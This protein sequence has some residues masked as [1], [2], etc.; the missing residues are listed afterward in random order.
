M[1]LVFV[2][3]ARLFDKNMKLSVDWNQNYKNRITREFQELE[4]DSCFLFLEYVKT[5]IPSGSDG[6]QCKYADFES[7]HGLGI[8]AVSINVPLIF[9]YLNVSQL[10]T[11]QLQDKLN[12]NFKNF[13]SISDYKITEANFKFIM[14]LEDCY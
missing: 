2:R 9:T 10:N 4:Y 8:S 1:L 7:N 5:L 11:E 6:G 12:N 13:Q 3:N 14:S